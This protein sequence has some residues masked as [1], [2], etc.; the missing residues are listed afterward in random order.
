MHIE[1][2]YRILGTFRFSFLPG[3]QAFIS[4]NLCCEWNQVTNETC[5]YYIGLR[6]L[7]SPRRTTYSR[8][9]TF[10]FY[11]YVEL[12]PVCH[13]GGTAVENSGSWSCTCTAQFTGKY[14]ETGSRHYQ[15]ISWY[16][17]VSRSRCNSSVLTG[18]ETH[19]M[20]AQPLPQPEQIRCDFTLSNPKVS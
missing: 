15:T 6:L 13:N 8:S 20:A 4:K 12:I 14:C 2:N 10:T 3:S 19:D 5:L 17:F 16:I 1:V 11:H 7:L 18:L 9:C